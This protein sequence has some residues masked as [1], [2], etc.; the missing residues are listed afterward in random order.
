M[1]GRILG[2][3]IGGAVA[4]QT[5]TVGGPTGAVLGAAVPMV[6]RRISIPGLIVLG[7]GGYAAKKFFFDAD[8]KAKP[9]PTEPT[10]DGSTVDRSTPQTASPAAPAVTTPPPG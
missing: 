8:D 2:A 3:W 7:A 1:I 9:Q 6:L 5:R 10:T 4:K